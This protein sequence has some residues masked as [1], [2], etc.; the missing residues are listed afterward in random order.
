MVPDEPRTGLPLEYRLAAIALMHYGVY[1]VRG[2]ASTVA[3]DP[4]S[5]EQQIGVLV[6]GSC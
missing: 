4:S 1:A 3:R 5:E 2:D 6:S